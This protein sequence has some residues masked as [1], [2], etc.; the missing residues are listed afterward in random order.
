MNVLFVC[1][2]NTCRSP[3]AEAIM[4]HKKQDW[5]VQSAGIYAASGGR[6]AAHAIQVL[7]EKEIAM[8]HISREISAE[9]VNWADVIFTMTHGHKQLI[10]GAFPEVSDKLWTLK[11]FVYERPEDVVDPYGGA[12]EDYRRTYEELDGLITEVLKKL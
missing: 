7:K 6:A 11:E 10:L 1:T 9:V 12:V 5:N 2:G 8:E 3:M 4:K